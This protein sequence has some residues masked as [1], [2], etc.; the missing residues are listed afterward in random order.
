MSN[1][2]ELCSNE[3]LQAYI[4]CFRYA[5]VLRTESKYKRM[6]I[7]NV[8]LE[9]YKYFPDINFDTAKRFVTRNIERYIKGNKTF[10]VYKDIS[11]FFNDG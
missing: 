6:E 7:C 8:L 10:M 9:P 5:D 1:G 11:T 4:F 3:Q 2:K